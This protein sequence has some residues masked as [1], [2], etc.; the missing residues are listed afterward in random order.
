MI[1]NGANL[2]LLNTGYKTAFRAGFAAVP[3]T[4]QRIATVVPSTTLIETYGWM[5][6]TSGMREWIGERFVK[7]LDSEIYQL[8]NRKF[9]ETVTVGRDVIEDDQYGTYTPAIGMLGEN[10]ARL[11]EEL[12]YLE[13]LPGGFTSKCYDGQYFF[14]ADHPVLLKDGSEVSVSNMQ[15]GASEAWYLL[16][17]KRTLKPFIYQDRAKAELIIKDNPETSDDVFNRDEFRYGTRARGAAGF[18]FWQTGFGSKA[19]LS[20][21]NFEAARTAMMKFKHDGGKPCGVVP[22]LLVVGPGNEAKADEILNVQRL[23]NGADNPNYKK[24]EI[25]VSPWLA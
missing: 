5:G 24:V 17:T 22:D 13:A 4:Y 20:K 19:D 10:A 3:L 25:L 7:N 11:P 14:D 23:A 8:K 21:A 9:E 2:S 1:I 15:A 12:I 18:G 6:Q 16:C